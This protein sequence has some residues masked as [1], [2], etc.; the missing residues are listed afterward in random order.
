LDI[1][2]NQSV[3]VTLQ[4]TKKFFQ[5]EDGDSKFRSVKGTDWKAI[6]KNRNGETIGQIYLILKE[7]KGSFH[8]TKSFG[9]NKGKWAN[10]IFPYMVEAHT[11][12][13][14]YKNQKKVSASIE[15]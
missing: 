4:L 9:H 2:P 6:L 3:P 7:K 14:Y 1:S 10:F 13:V 5:I 15:N 8:S 12:D 11:V